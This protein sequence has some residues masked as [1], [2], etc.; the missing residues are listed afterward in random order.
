MTEPEHRAEVVRGEFAVQAGAG[1][2]EADRRVHLAGSG[3]GEGIGERA[4][5][6]RL[7]APG[8][9]VTAHVQEVDGLRPEVTDQFFQL[10]RYAFG[11]LVRV[12]QC[13]GMREFRG[14]P[15]QCGTGWCDRTG[16]GRHC[17]DGRGDLLEAGEVAGSSWARYRVDE[18]AVPRV[19]EDHRL[20]LVAVQGGVK[21]CGGD[22][23]AT[24]SCCD[25]QP[26]HAAQRTGSNLALTL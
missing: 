4:L 10:T 25:D 22:C 2:Q 3:Q 5:Q 14:E 24:S 26:R 17:R 8:E 21:H 12:E 11:T 16:L 6:R 1:D 15:R 20:V 7:V 9:D 18:Q 23:V 13:E 19:R